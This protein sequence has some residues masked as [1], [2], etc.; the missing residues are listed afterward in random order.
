MIALAIMLAAAR[1]SDAPG[2]VGPGT[3]TCE[4]AMKPE[5]MGR[6]SDYVWGVWSGMNMAGNTPTV[7][8]STDE[9]GIVKEVIQACM[10]QPKLPLALAIFAIHMRMEREKR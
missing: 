6:V 1:T 8:H 3:V 7:G 2:V 5:L 9:H 4:R 10:S